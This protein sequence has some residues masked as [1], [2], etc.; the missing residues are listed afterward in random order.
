[1]AG[2]KDFDKYLLMKQ[3]REQYRLNKQKAGASVSSAGRPRPYARKNIAAAR[4][5]SP[6]VVGHALTVK[7]TSLMQYLIRLVT[8]RRGVILDPFMGSGSTGKAAMFENKDRDAGYKFVGIELTDEYLPIAKAR[9]EF[10]RC[11]VMKHG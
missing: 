7:P 9:I 3:G 11:G 10:A 5:Y 4:L 6:Q 1:M 8:P 2:N